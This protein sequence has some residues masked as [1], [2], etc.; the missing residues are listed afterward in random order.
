MFLTLAVIGR[1][2]GTVP[3]SDRD[4]HSFR[5]STYTVFLPMLANLPGHKNLSDFEG[6]G[7]WGGMPEDS[8]A[9]HLVHEAEI[10]AADAQTARDRLRKLAADF[11]QECIA[12]TP[13]ID[14]Q[15]VEAAS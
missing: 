12:F 11:R 7:D 3:M 5:S 10:P 1:N 14:S 2:V 15:L 6:V 8:M 13:N 4:W 9:L